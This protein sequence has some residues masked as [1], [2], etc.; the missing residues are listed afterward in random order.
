MSHCTRASRDLSPP[1]KPRYESGLARKRPGL[2]PKHVSNCPLSSE[3]EVMLKTCRM[4]FHG[5]SCPSRGAED[6]VDDSLRVTNNVKRDGLRSSYNVP[7]EGLFRVGHCLSELMRRG[8]GYDRQLPSCRGCAVSWIASTS[9]MS[10]VLRLCTNCLLRR[11][12][13]MKVMSS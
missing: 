7:N 6:S 8:L 5:S 11:T 1:M 12:G 13:A 3:Y 2:V 9:L 10:P 4:L